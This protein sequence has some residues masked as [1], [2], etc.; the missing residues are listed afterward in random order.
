MRME[1]ID[2]CLFLF[3]LQLAFLQEIVLWLLLLLF[4]F[5]VAFATVTHIRSPFIYGYYSPHGCLATEHTENSE[6][7]FFSDDSVIS[8]EG[9]TLHGSGVEG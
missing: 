6:F 7:S 2:L 1:G 8:P 3:L 9:N 4:L 5:L